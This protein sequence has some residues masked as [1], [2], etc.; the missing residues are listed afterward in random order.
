MHAGHA[1]LLRLDPGAWQRG[2]TS[3]C[4]AISP[5]PEG[6]YGLHASQARSAL[7]TAFHCFMVLTTLH[8]AAG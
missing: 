5:W 3:W 2:S 6:L 8:H 4:F 7:F 1:R